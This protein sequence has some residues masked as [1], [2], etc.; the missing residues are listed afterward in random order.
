VLQARLDR[1]LSDAMENPVEPMPSHK[2][3]NAGE[4]FA[5]FFYLD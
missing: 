2:S 4:N 3:S 5:R 1:V